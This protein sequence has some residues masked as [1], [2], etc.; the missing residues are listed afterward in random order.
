MKRINKLCK[1]LVLEK[2]KSYSENK[3]MEIR[4]SNIR[5]LKT[6]VDNLRRYNTYRVNQL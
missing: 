6:F 1:K 2:K 5:K 4:R 3:S